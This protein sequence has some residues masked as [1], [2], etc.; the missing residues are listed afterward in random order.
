[1]EEIKDKGIVI[2]REEYK[3]ADRLIYLFTRDNGYIVVRF[4]GVRKPNA[5]LQP[6]AN[7]FC[8]DEVVCLKRQ[9]FYTVKT[10]SLIE[11]MKFTDSDYDKVLCCFSV[12]ELVK[13]LIPKHEKMT[14]MFDLLVETYHNINNGVIYEA[15]IKFMLE[16]MRM[17]GECPNTNV[18]GSHVY[19][20]M[21]YADFSTERTPGC[22]E[23]D[24][25]CYDMIKRVANGESCDD[26]SDSVKV[27]ATKFFRNIMLIKYKLEMKA[28]ESM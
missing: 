16:F 15:T 25:K 3:E 5:K 17:M 19:L 11:G 24:S 8:Y 13:N 22:I 28:L 2:Y 6:L 12:A 21:Q 9:D 10:G 27:K 18:Q 1:M 7:L 4:K 20:D 26:V 14:E 23:I